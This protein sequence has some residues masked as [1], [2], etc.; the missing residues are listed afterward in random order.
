LTLN[1]KTNY[2]L[3]PEEDSFFHVKTCDRCGISLVIGRTTSW[4]TDETICMNC[5][6][7]EDTL[8]R[9]M[10]SGGLNPDR[11]EGCGETRFESLKREFG[12]D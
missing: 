6:D 3:K 9:K 4:F 10:R 1:W 2:W 8:K 12:E 7:K 5:A 11:Y